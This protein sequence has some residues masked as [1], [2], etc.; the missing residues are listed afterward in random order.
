MRVV[1]VS[2]RRLRFKPLSRSRARAMH[3][4]MKTRAY[5]VPRTGRA[6]IVRIFR[7]NAI[8][9]AGLWLLA[10]FLVAAYYGYWSPVREWLETIAASK[11]QLGF[12]FAMISTSLFGGVIPALVGAVFHGAAGRG[13][14]RWLPVFAAFWAYKGI[15][16][17]LLYRA[18]EWLFG[19]G[20]DP[21]TIASKMVVDMGV[22]VPVLAMPS[23]VLFYFLK[24][25]R[26]DIQLA[27][28][29]LGR[30]WYRARVLP[31]LAT[32]WIVWIPAVAVIY[33]FPPTLQLPVQNLVLCFFCLVVLMLTRAEEEE[34]V[35]R[36]NARPLKEEQT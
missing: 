23:I 35:S 13:E 20:T 8:P 6:S 30:D 22:Y 28:R 26:F 10:A 17:D 12:A 24:E 9:A 1:A 15:E 34:P 5:G 27:L 4:A 32:N 3:D 36:S 21:A 33:S 11:Q 14:L 2:E 29:S 31:V 16:V 19:A 25:C 18:M 7:R